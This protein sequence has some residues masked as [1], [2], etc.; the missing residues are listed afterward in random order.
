MSVL[1]FPSSSY[2]GFSIEL[3]SALTVVVASNIGLPVST[4]HCKVRGSQHC[5]LGTRLSGW[6]AAGS[7]SSA[8]PGVL[9]CCCF[10]GG[11]RGG[12]GMAALQEGRGLAALQE[13]LHG[14]VCDCAH[15]GPDQCRHHGHLHL[16]HPVEPPP[17]PPSQR[18]DVGQKEEKKE[19]APVGAPRDKGVKFEG[20][21]ISLTSS[22]RLWKKKEKKNVWM[23]LVIWACGHFQPSICCLFQLGHITCISLF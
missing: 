18:E 10:P 5:G 14:V 21:N 19:N 15:L 20:Q 4:T 6:S 22:Q 13:H 11:L 12:G 3:A 23:D 1:F 7:E 9:T 17:P 2:S 8:P 16:R